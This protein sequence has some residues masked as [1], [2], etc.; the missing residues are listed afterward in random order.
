M[1]SST[2]R[3]RAPRRSH[4]EW[5][6]GPDRE[7]P[8][9]VL[10]RQA[11]SR[12]PE[13]VPI[14][15]GR[16]LASPFAFY[17]GAAAIMAA[18]L[19]PVPATGLTVQ[20]CG[21]AHLANFGAFA[22]PD[23]SLVFDVNDFDETHP[24][25]FEWDVKRLAA[26]V[27]IL[28]RERGLPRGDRRDAVLATVGAYREAMHAFTEMRSLEV[29]YARLDVEP[30]LARRDADLSR[31]RRKNLDRTVA[32]A[33]RKDSLRALSKL[34]YEEGGT[35]R[36]VSDPPI[37]VPIADLVGPG[38]EDRVRAAVGRYIDAYRATLEPDRRH[39]LHDYRPVDIAHKVVGVGSVGTRAWIV[40]L[41]G[42]DAGDPLFLQVKEAQASVLA[43][44]AG[45]RAGINQGRRVVEGQRLMQAASDLFLGWLRVPHD[46]DGRRRD[47][48]VRQLWDAK[49]SVPLDALT[50]G[51]LTSYARTCGWTL[52]RA[53][54]R[55]G[56][57]RAIA[58]YLGAG[59]RFDQAL[60]TFA[61]TYAEC[62]ERDHAALADAVQAGAV[63]VADPGR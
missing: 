20:L 47:Y 22:A 29:W 13:L 38:D 56:D 53:H 45:G 25:P 52:A 42:A 55:S 10:Q 62:N 54:A 17:R 26:S 44:Y 23:R 14:R 63:A 60:A 16:M 21:D 5:R 49:G 39:A 15:Y 61:E 37:V 1:T 51:E 27:A 30:L 32:K 18:D 34:T 41:L 31:H 50:P 7:D 43:P 19:A 58:A 3:G 9:A 40:L 59:D 36:I 48:F 24:G 57:R 35:P 6:P 46:L 8:V 11:A 2:P 12:V 4:G 33:K 28:G